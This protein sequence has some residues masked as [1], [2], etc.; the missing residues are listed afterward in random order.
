MLLN[1]LSISHHP[2][3]FLTQNFGRLLPGMEKIIVFYFDERD[4][5]IKCSALNSDEP[6]S[7]TIS[8][9]Y[10]PKIQRQRAS[11]QRYEWYKKDYELL[12]LEKASNASPFQMQL[13]DE[14]NLNLL[15]LRFENP[16][17]H[18]NDLVLIHF[19]DK[20]G[21]LKLATEN[22]T[23]SSSE[24]NI[25]E[26]LLYNQIAFLL[27]NERSNKQLYERIMEN[28][29]VLKKTN[30]LLKNEVTQ[31]EV[32][33]KK[34]ISYFCRNHLDVVAKKEKLKLGITDDAIALIIEKNIPFDRIH[35]MLN[36]SI[37]L[38]LNKGLHE[39]DEKIVIDEYDLVFPELNTAQ[40][41]VAENGKIA[42]VPLH[43]R[44]AKTKEY[45]DRYEKA[46][47]ELLQNGLALTGANIGAYCSPKITPAAIS[48]NLKKHRSKII[49]LLFRYNE[50]WPIIRESYRPIRK[51]LDQPNEGLD[52]SKAV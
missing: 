36:K 52:F 4:F 46:A 24:K 35:L 13:D 6:V 45:L 39:L 31:K 41:G 18:L 33:Y 12:H 2:F 3:E 15:V 11:G 20:I 32:S 28:H 42:E 16:V 43:D 27:Q 30:Q 47:E 7:L 22:D 8:E 37:E 48:D 5:Q 40:T 34:S 1:R 38:C 10:L 17:D 50:K 19:H 21:T 44:Y 26:R 23:I 29:R 51:L 9:E 49:T 14:A 25:I